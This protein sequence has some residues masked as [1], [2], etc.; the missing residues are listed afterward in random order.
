M[1]TGT[2]KPGDHTYVMTK[3]PLMDMEAFEQKVNDTYMRH[4]PLEQVGGMVDS[5]RL[6]GLPEV[7]TVLLDMTGMPTTPPSNCLAC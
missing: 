1:V 6:R 3:A 5:A 2:P 4:A 7:N